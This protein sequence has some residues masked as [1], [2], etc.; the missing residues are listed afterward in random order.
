MNLSK[1]PVKSPN[2]MTFLILEP[3]HS[4]ESPRVRRIKNPAAQHIVYDQVRT[5]DPI[6]DIVEQLVG[7]GVRSMGSKT[8]YEIPRFLEALLNGTKIGRSIP[9]RT[10]MCWQSVLPLTI[11][12]WRMAD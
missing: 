7:P 5:Y 1:N 4:S 8:E 9:I 6:I 12:Q 11:C 2:I 10:M 3:G